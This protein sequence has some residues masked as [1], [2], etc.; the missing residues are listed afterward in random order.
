M[1]SLCAFSVFFLFALFAF[2]LNVQAAESVSDAELTAISGGLEC[3]C[4]RPT[5]CGE[6]CEV[7]GST[8]SGLGF[9]T[10]KC[11][12]SEPAIWYRACRPNS[13][14]IPYLCEST[15]QFPCSDI[16]MYFRGPACTQ[17]P[18]YYAIACTANEAS[19]LSE[20]C[21]K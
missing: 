21:P 20:D 9:I 13:G 18:F 6:V 4:V 3:P 19:A 2:S 16:T 14:P 12:S 1:K 8:G 17:G 11:L 10:Q 5:T 7:V 15:S